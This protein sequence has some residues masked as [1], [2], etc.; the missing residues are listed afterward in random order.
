MA[1]AA[2]IAGASVLGAVASNKASKRATSAQQA[3]ADTAAGQTKES[4]AQAR[5]DLFKLFPAAQQNAQQG[6]QGALDVFNQSVPAQMSAF[7]GGNVAA[8]QQILAGLGQQQNALLGNNVDL[9]QLQAYQAP[10]QDLSFLSQQLPQYIDPFA[11]PPQQDFLGDTQ[12]GPYTGPRPTPNGRN[13]LSGGL[14]FGFGAAGGG[15]GSGGGGFGGLGR[16]S[17]RV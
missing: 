1:T 9:S 12:Q 15:G 2:V 13:I 6:F 3:A 10:Q 11:P 8:Q 4:T 14:G 16:F 7:Q 5:A 17:R